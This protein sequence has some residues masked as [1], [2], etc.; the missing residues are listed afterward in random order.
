MCAGMVLAPVLYAFLSDSR[1][2]TSVSWHLVYPLSYYSRL[3]RAFFAPDSPYWL[4]MGYA[5]SVLLALMLLFIRK[6]ENALLKRLF[7]V[8]ML[9]VLSPPLG[10]LLNGMSY[11]SNKW[12][13]ALALLCSY[14]L[15]V[16]WPKFMDLRFKDALMLAVL[17]VICFF[18]ILMLE[19]SRGLETFVGV[20]IAFVF[21]I[22]IMPYNTDDADVTKWRKVKPII[23]LAL[24]VISVANV[25]FFWNSSTM[26]GYAEKAIESERVE[27]DLMHTEAVAVNKV[28]VVDGVDDFYRYSGRSLTK[29]AGVLSGISSTQFYWSVSNPGISD[30]MR[31]TEQLETIA[32]D[33][34]GYDDR[35][36]LLSLSSVLYYVLPAND[37]APVPY[38]FVIENISVSDYQV[39][40]NKYALPL[41]Y[42]YDSAVDESTWN[43]LSAIEK[44]E[45]MLQAIYIPDYEGDMLTDDVA[46][47]SKT[48][49]YS[50]KCNSADITIEDYGLVVA[51]PNSSITIDFNGIA[52]SETYFVIKGLDYDGVSNY[53][54]YFGDPKYDPLDLYNQARWDSMSYAD[55][56]S[57]RK[58]AFFGP[59]R[60]QLSLR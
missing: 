29:N 27:N 12:C 30:Y 52:G 18:L 19:Y 9:I 35:A 51:K 5:A 48:L 15:T 2:S 26:Q 22:A 20:G 25:S 39:F 49:D 57:S 14:I 36:S 31:E 60:L 43:S 55:K 50:T 1:M 8:C 59:N 24:V 42:C 13:W 33:H 10:Q 58:K 21:L 56:E 41:G 3:F 32:Q 7:C 44:Q 45:A 11:Q 37:K 38:G 47:S 54:L 6:D 16:M 53:D 40:R 23:C 17:L 46:L 28:A 4:C 34:T